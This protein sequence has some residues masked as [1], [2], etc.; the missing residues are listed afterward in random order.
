[1]SAQ[2]RQA[3]QDA[4]ARLMYPDRWRSYYLSAVDALQ[5]I[6]KSQDGEV[7]A[8]STRGRV[9]VTSARRGL[10]W[11]LSEQLGEGFFEII[12][13]APGKLLRV[14]RFILKKSLHNRVCN[15]GQLSFG[16]R[17]KGAGDFKN[18]LVFPDDNSS[19]AFWGGTSADYKNTTLLPADGVITGVDIGL[20]IPGGIELLNM[21]SPSLI[22]AL[23]E[24]ES[25]LADSDIMFSWFRSSG[26]A[27]R[28]MG[29]MVH[30]TYS[31]A[32]RLDYM[33]A[34][35]EELCC[36][37]ADAYLRSTE[38]EKQGAYRANHHDVHALEKSR[39]M[40]QQGYREK[41]HVDD[42]A[43]DIGLSPNR[44]RAL[45]KQ[46]YGE[47]VQE[48]LLNIR[49]T[50]ARELLTG[51]ELSIDDVAAQVG[52]RHASGFRQAFKKYYGVSPK[53]I[54]YH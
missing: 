25:E 5:E 29:E 54:R 11:Q 32:L 24:A 44:F 41:L 14:Y 7:L 4:I 19:I 37:I 50:K 2:P 6:G 38:K 46:K 9:E 48:F 10:R 45:F 31:G 20:P 16:V 28:C 53:L 13:L 33:C 3:P 12:E 27:V 49:M 39:R 1:M 51:T 42:I 15:N 52:Y 23:R 22:D 35:A 18:S 47:G 8:E 36:H 21:H 26:N 34:K 17:A 43:R 30:C 40:I